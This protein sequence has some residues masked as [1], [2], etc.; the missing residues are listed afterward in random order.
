MATRFAS[1][2]FALLWLAQSAVAA[3]A[4][5]GRAELSATSITVTDRVTLTVT[6]ETDPDYTV[7]PW[8]DDAAKQLEGAGWTVVSTTADAPALHDGRIERT[9][10]LLLE[11]FLDGDYD[12]PAITCTAIGPAGEKQTVELAA[13]KVEVTSR[14]PADETVQL[15]LPGLPTATPSDGDRPL[16]EL[17]VVP[18]P[19]LAEPSAFLVGAIIV[20]LVAAAGI[21]VIVVGAAGKRRGRP[22]DVWR[23]LER[24]TKLVRSVDDLGP[25]DRAFRACLVLAPERKSGEAVALLERLERARY[26]KLA[27]GVDACALADEVARV[28]RALREAAGGAA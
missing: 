10:R 24:S 2:I 7:E 6:L 20:P 12:V 15:P 9:T 21:V 5:A 27:R 23:E 11:P 13:S 22:S 17:R 1:V 14:L 28:A 26:A 16:G 4:I 19:K 3:Q 25:V 8:K 18:G